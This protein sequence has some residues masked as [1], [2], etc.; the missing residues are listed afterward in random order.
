MKN[1]TKKFRVK[2]TFTTK[3]G[4]K[5]ETTCRITSRKRGGLGGGYTCKERCKVKD[6]K[7]IKY[8]SDAGGTIIMS[9]VVDHSDPNVQRFDRLWTMR[10]EKFLYC[11]GGR[12]ECVGYG[13]PAFVERNRDNNC[14]WNECPEGCSFVADGQGNRGLCDDD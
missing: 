12:R 7:G 13:A 10:P 2:T 14:Q 9:G 3:S 4:N 11:S 5:V 8:P 1:G 6:G